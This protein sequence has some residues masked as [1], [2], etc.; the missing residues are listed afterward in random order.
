MKRS[1]SCKSLFW[2]PIT[3]IL[4][5]SVSRTYNDNDEVEDIR[6][7]FDPSEIPPAGASEFAVGDDEEDE[8][9]QEEQ[10]KHYGDLDD[11]EV[12]KSRDEDEQH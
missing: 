1:F 6:H 3:G 9:G 11:R 8:A 5:S 2:P 10:N 12:W 7:G 4:L